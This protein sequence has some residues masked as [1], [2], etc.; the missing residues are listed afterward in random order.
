MICLPSDERQHLKYALI[1]GFGETK[2][3]LCASMDEYISDLV[4]GIKKGKNSVSL[5]KYTEPQTVLIDDLQ[6][7]KGKNQTQEFFYR[8]LKQRLE[9]K[10]VTI[11]FSKYELDHLRRTFRDDLLNFLNLGCHTDI[12]Q[13]VQVQAVPQ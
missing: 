3:M 9:N 11:L 8:I 12:E 1:N 13:S 2:D 5:S 4:S 6:L 7:L 10:K